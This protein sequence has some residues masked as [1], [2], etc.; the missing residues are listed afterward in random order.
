MP[1]RPTVLVTGGAGYIGSHVVLALLEAGRRVLVLDNLSAG[2][3]AAVP[4]GVPF[5]EA[6]VSDAGRTEA[7][8]R[9]YGV[10]TVMHFA[11]SISVPESIDKPDLYW[12]N[13]TA[14]TLDLATA[15]VRA[16]VPRLVFSSTAAVYGESSDSPLTEDAPTAPLNPYGRSKLAAEWLLADIEAATGLRCLRLRYFNAAG[17]D[18]QGRTG[19]HGGSQHLIR[20][21]CLTALG[22]RPR[23][24]IFGDDYRTR[25]GTCERDFIHVADLADVHVAALGYLEGGGAGMVMNVGYGRGYTV[26]EVVA[27]VER[28]TGRPLPAS[29]GPRRP[30][31]PASVVADS[32]RAHTLLGWTPRH[33]DLDAI[34]ASTLAWEARYG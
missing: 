31:D 32:T 4:D 20:V 26:R 8:L 1:D 6:H 18:P 10:G 13:N 33:D 3:R 29:V 27:A 19:Q 24:E 16:G 14:A 9:Q 21:A 7:I 11:G 23:L 30:G 22:R 34:I 15:C 5:I 25:D 2:Q 12:R 28:V 17:A